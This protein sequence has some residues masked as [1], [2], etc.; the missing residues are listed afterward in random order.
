MCHNLE[1]GFH[2]QEQ[3]RKSTETGPVFASMQARMRWS[4]NKYASI[5]IHNKNTYLFRIFIDVTSDLYSI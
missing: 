1:H 5:I 4:Y 3:T 2:S